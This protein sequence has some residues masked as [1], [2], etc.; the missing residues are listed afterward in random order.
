MIDHDSIPNFKFLICKLENLHA[1]GLH[2]GVLRNPIHTGGPPNEVYHSPPSGLLLGVRYS[3]SDG[4]QFGEPGTAQT[5]LCVA[6]HSHIGGSPAVRGAR[7]WQ[8]SSEP[9][10]VKVKTNVRES[11]KRK[12]RKARRAAAPAALAQ[13]ST[14]TGSE[15]MVGGPN[16]GRLDGNGDQGSAK[17]NIKTRPTLR[18][19]G[20]T[21]GGSALEGRGSRA[22]NQEDKNPRLH[23]R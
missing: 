15:K 17:G 22:F 8:F 6:S 12:R 11:D 2:H 7:M 23:T 3:R 9:L 13:P 19:Q 5:R 14:S 21:A 1:D 16:T 10:K 20:W 4:L 18:S